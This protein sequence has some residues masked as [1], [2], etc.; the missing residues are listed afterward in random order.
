MWIFPDLSG[1]KCFL[2]EI[3]KYITFFFI[4]IHIYNLAA[5]HSR[6]HRFD[7][8]LKSLARRMICIFPSGKY[9]FS[10]FCYENEFLTIIAKAKKK[11]NVSNK[12]V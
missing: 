3:E 8:N 7:G 2:V 12:S 5:A 1:I 9:L 10:V 6:F 4:Y 11:R